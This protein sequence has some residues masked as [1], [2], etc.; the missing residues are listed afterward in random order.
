[1]LEVVVA[2]AIIVVLAV[3]SY[4][5]LSPVLVRGCKSPQILSNAKQLHLATQQMAL[6]ATTAGNRKIGWPGNI[7]GTFANW[8]HQLVAGEYLTTNDFCKL[9]SGPGMVVPLNQIPTKNNNALLIYDVREES[10]GSTVFLTSANFTN[11]PTGGMPPT[12]ESKPYGDKGFVVFRKAGD[13]AILLPSQ[14]GKTN[15][16]GAFVPLCQ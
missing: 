13:G 2:L 9:L 12:K 16:I 15:L 6:D 5:A 3:V 14:V 1:M 10:E 4:S 7:G 11:T 8:A